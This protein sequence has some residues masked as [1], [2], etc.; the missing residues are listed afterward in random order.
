MKTVN[1]S[2]LIWYSPEEMYALVTDVA[3][4]PE[5]LPWCDQAQVVEQDEAGML[6]EM[7][8]TFS[9]IH[10][11]FTTRNEHVPGRVVHMQL[12]KGPFSKLD[13]DWHFVPLG[14]GIQR[15]CRVELTLDYGFDNRDAGGAGRPGVRQDC[16]QPGRCVRQARRAGLWL[17]ACQ[18]G[19]TRRLFA[20]RAAGL[21]SECWSCET[22]ATVRQAVQASGCCTAFPELD[23]SAR[24]GWR[25]G[26]QGRL[27]ARSCANG[28]RVEIYRPLQVDPKVARRERFRKQGARTAGLFAHKRAGAKAGY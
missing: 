20:G 9:G 7:G 21:R 5:F 11:T 14:D 16:G 13:G 6:A 23:L 24:D 27:R 10:Q 3:H 22:G 4:Y 1:K 12:V 2:V 18:S 17:S 28:D 19:V 25:L 26:P 15:A 8:I